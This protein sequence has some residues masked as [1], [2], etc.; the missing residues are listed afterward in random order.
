LDLKKRINLIRYYENRKCLDGG[1]YGLDKIWELLRKSS[2]CLKK[3]GY[4]VIEMNE[5]Q[6][7]YLKQYFNDNGGVVHNLK[8]VD[9]KM[10]SE[11]KWTFLV[12]QK[13]V[14][15]STKSKVPESFEVDT[16]GAL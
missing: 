15:P 10:D 1:E 11:W 14:I 4:L 3:N 7:E 5:G 2:D 9:L 16:P 12:L 13:E 6:P 8:I